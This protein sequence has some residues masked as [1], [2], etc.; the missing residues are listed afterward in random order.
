MSFDITDAYENIKQFR[1]ELDYV[2]LRQEYILE[3]LKEEG[4]HEEK[5]L[6]EYL[7]KIQ[8]QKTKEEK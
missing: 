8:E 6:E 2:I 7:K 4:M 3:L 5:D 1:T